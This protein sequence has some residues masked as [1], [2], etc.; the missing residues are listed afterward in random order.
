[1]A[2]A[3]GSTRIFAIADHGGADTLWVRVSPPPEPL[4]ALSRMVL[5]RPAS[6]NILPDSLVV[7][8]GDTAALTVATHPGCD[9][10]YFP[11]N[12]A[13]ALES[14]D[15][16]IVRIEATTAKQW[17]IETITFPLSIGTNA[18]I[19]GVAAGRTELVATAPYT[20]PKR[21]KIIVQ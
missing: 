18:R 6:H 3:P 12:Y 4:A 20:A 14:A 1:M 19:R 2:R 5:D 17:Q 13:V 8:R 10:R 9:A 16:S 11:S 21:I 7:A 15:P